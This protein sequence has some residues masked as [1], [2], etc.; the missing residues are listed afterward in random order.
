MMSE[1]EPQKR[2]TDSVQLPLQGIRRVR[3]HIRERISQENTRLRA[4]N[5]GLNYTR[6]DV[7]SQADVSSDTLDRFL[8]ERCGKVSRK[9][10]EK[11]TKLLELDLDDLIESNRSQ[12]P[13]DFYVERPPL[14]DL[15]YEEIFSDASTLVR[16]KAPHRTGKTWFVEQLMN[17]EHKTLFLKVTLSFHNADKD[18]FTD[19]NKFLKWFCLSIGNSLDLLNKLDEK[20]QDGLGSNSNCINYFETYLWASIKTPL[21]LILEDVD[22][23]FEQ[24]AV[25]GDFCSL[26]RS[27]HDAARRPNN[28]SWQYPR[29]VI[30]HS[31]D[32]YGGLD[33]NQSPLAAVGPVFSLRNFNFKEVTILIQQYKF[34]W[35]KD[36]IQQFVT[37]TGGNP[38]LVHNAL[39]HLKR[40]PEIKLEIFLKTAAIGISPYHN[41][42]YELLVT[43]Q[44][45]KNLVSAFKDV[46]NSVTPV[47]VEDE[48][49]FQLYSMG[50]IEWVEGGAVSSCE[51][52][53]QYFCDRL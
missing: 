11:I 52:Y 8:G 19:L 2:K 32:L 15:C 49:K 17:R 39:N 41:H 37:L 23:V 5:S 46:V 45:N 34:L 36:Q 16:V 24:P 3:D 13:S 44:K 53:R 22:L 7:A 33:I 35:K 25:S 50:L 12:R 31:T 47:K 48:H 38:Y 29:V 30:V 21:V 9:Y 6:E 1:P 42:L 4:E 20:L 10:A 18:I 51:L 43:L 28:K 26:L 27:W 40:N 14:E